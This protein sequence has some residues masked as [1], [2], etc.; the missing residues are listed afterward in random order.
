[1]GSDLLHFSS[2]GSTQKV[3]SKNLVK[4]FFYCFIY[5]FFSSGRIYKA[6]GSAEKLSRSHGN[7]ERNLQ[8]TKQ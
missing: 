3:K 8:L 4:D 7:P 2:E 5:G 6:I 1:M